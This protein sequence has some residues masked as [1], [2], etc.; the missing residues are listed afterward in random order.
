MGKGMGWDEMGLGR[1][2]V[3]VI[4]GFTTLLVCVLSR[5]MVLA[6]AGL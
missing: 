6:S 4:G 3:L 5:F 2:L 1:V